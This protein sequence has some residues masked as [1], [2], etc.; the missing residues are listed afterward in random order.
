MLPFFIIKGI[1]MTEYKI[2]LIPSLVE[3]ARTTM[4]RGGQEFEVKVPKVLELSDEE[5]RVFVNDWRFTVSDST[6]SSKKNS[7]GNVKKGKTISSS[8]SIDGTETIVDTTQVVE[9]KSVAQEKKDADNS[10]KIPSLKDLKKNYSREELD[11]IAIEAGLNPEGFN[12]KSEVAQA[13]VEA[14]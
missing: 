14:R 10:T 5:V 7:S 12:N 1:I 11:T 2:E 6:D 9:D 4:F 3:G 13:I 8:G